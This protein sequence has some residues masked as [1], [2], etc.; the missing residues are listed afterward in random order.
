MIMNANHIIVYDDYCGY[1]LRVT[2]IEGRWWVVTP[3]ERLQRLEEYY[4]SKEIGFCCLCQEGEKVGAVAL[5]QMLG[6]AAE[7]PE[8]EVDTTL[9]NRVEHLRRMGVEFN[10][11][12][13]PLKLQLRVL[14]NK[15]GSQLQGKSSLSCQ[16]VN[17]MLCTLFVADCFDNEKDAQEWGQI[18]ISFLR[19]TLKMDVEVINVNN[20]IKGEISYGKDQK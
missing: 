6:R 20:K 16:M 17:N 9:Y 14:S 15:P 7:N 18:Y 5:A 3:G 2:A 13:E 1:P 12:D 8:M 19:D 11:N 4:K 10:L